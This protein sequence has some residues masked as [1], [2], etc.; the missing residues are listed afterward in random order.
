MQRNT[1][2]TLSGI[3][4]SPLLLFHL[5]PQSLRSTYYNWGQSQSRSSSVLLHRWILLLPW[6][7]S[8]CGHSAAPLY[9]Y[10]S[11]YTLG[12]RLGH[13]LKS[14]RPE[15]LQYASSEWTVRK[16]RPH[17][18]T[19][20]WDSLKAVFNLGIGFK[21]DFLWSRVWD[22]SF[23]IHHLRLDHWIVPHMVCM[24]TFVFFFNMF[25]NPEIWFELL[26]FYFKFETDYIEYIKVL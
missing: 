1:L 10:P 13:L 5:S 12:S 8:P 9:T 16:R 24:Y 6:K 21:A 22:G 3:L 7:Y 11:S 17:I 18:L 14:W 20:V 19:Y 2:L 15:Y 26:L 25:R 4:S 23:V